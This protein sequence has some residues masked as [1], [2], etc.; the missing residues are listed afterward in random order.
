M[1]NY[2]SF[3]KDLPPNLNVW[4]LCGESSAGYCSP[5]GTQR[6][7][8][9]PSGSCG[10][11]CPRDRSEN[12]SRQ[13]YL[14]SFQATQDGAAPRCDMFSLVKDHQDQARYVHEKVRGARQPFALLGQDW[15]EMRKK[16]N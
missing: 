9:W 6:Y 11:C 7:P 1:T 14:V 10:N 12:D 4:S 16:E 15:R 13:E 5:L 2:S 8:L 3:Y